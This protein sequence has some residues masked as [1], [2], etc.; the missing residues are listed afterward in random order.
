MWKCANLKSEPVAV[1]IH[2]YRLKGAA[3][4]RHV[5]M[6]EFKVGTRCCTNLWFQVKGGG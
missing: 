6:Y 2:G 1:R 3:E 4:S 5:E